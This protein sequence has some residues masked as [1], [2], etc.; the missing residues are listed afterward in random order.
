M[1]MNHQR[2]SLSHF[3]TPRV[4]GAMFIQRRELSTCTGFGIAGRSGHRERWRR[5]RNPLHKT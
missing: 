2:T 3:D 4:S 1:L 5:L